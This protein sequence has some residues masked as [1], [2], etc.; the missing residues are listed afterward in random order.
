MERKL[1]AILALDVVGYSALMEADEAGTFDRVTRG[2][3]ELFEPEVARRH[4]RIFKVMGDGLLAE[5]GSVVDAVECAVTLQRGMAERNA[6]VT[7]VRQFEIRIGI[8][9]GE[10]IVEG[11]DRYGEGV[12]VAARLQEL[13]EPSGICVSEKVSKEVKKKLSFGFEPMGEQR[14]K[15]IAEPIACFRVKLQ[16]PH[17][18]KSG[19]ASPKRPELSDKVTIAVLPFK[20]MSSDPEQE[21]FAEGLAE[22]LITDLSKVPGLMVIA[23]NSSFVYKGKSVD[24]RSVASDLGVRYVIE[25]SVRR[26]ASR[27]RINAQL[28]DASVNSHIWADRFDS[29]LADVFTLQDEVVRK[30]VDALSG[31]LPSRRP[32]A[33]RRITDLDAYDLFIRARPLVTR[34]PEDN[35]M[36][37]PML[38]RAVEI[39]AGFAEAHA[40]LAMSY[41]FGW[42]H[43]G[44]PLHHTEAVAAALHSVSLDPQ[45]AVGHTTLGCVRTFEPDLDEAVAEFETAL[46]INPNHADAW[47]FFAD[48]RVF[49]GR[50]HEA[51]DCAQTAF[52]LNPYPPTHYYWLLGWAQYAA[53]QYE[54]AVA[55][56]RQKSADLTGP[57][58]ILA[59]SLAML[60][61]QEEAEGAARQF[62][63][64]NPRFSI[65]QWAT[66]QPFKDEA[67]KQHFIVGYRKAGL[68][69]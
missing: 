49:Q 51:V 8:N 20:N 32:L 15:N 46:Q 42:L 3:K 47:A 44:Q 52:R 31:A 4:G 35:Q 5:F 67:D 48:L 23:R 16:V 17:S 38:E 24:L 27:V 36:A 69:E 45:N 22:D 21:F 59:A 43:W 2:R 39:D 9:L 37:Q 30:I 53:Q 25:G 56:L 62:L 50:P 66:T 40:W 65:R 14:M 13:A 6:S 1:A 29:E 54:D 18:G 63:A 34:S 58:R 55:S 64:A 61:R 60:G 68:P 41:H 7:D 10:V 57:G 19:R 33:K 12:N 28:I 26:A 11:D